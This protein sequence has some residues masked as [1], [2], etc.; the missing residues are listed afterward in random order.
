MR[1]FNK[2]IVKARQ[3]I[4]KIYEYLD[5]LNTEVQYEFDR[6]IER[7]KKAR[8]EDCGLIIQ[9]IEQRMKELSK[10]K[11]NIVTN[12]KLEELASILDWI[13]GEEN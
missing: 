7:L 1:E 13:D 12:A 2:K 9:K 6:Q 3:D 5:V 8:Y 10:V 4:K 11:Q